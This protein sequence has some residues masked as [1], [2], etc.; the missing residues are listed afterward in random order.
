M[1]YGKPAPLKVLPF[2]KPGFNR[3]V[4]RERKT[5]PKGEPCFYMGPGANHPR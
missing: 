1:F 4:R 2:L 3:V 5:D